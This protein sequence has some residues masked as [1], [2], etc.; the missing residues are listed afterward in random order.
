[1]NASET[2]PRDARSSDL[3]VK[4]RDIAIDGVRIFYREAGPADASVVLLPHGYPSSSFQFRNFMPVHDGQ[5]MGQ[6]R[7]G[8]ADFGT[9][10]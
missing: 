5:F 2:S 3:T 1:M 8:L 7:A 6:S 10:R 9:D 4:H